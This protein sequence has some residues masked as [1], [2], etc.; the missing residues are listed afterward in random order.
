MVLLTV[1]YVA[2]QC[3][4]ATYQCIVAVQCSGR[5]L[6]CTNVAY[7]SAVVLPPDVSTIMLTV[8]YAAMQCIIAMYQ[9]I[10][11]VQCST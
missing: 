9:C 8:R 10:L 1:R 4:I 3:I 6:L 2:M 11:A 5:M 7:V